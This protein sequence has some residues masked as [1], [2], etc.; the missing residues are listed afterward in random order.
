MHI[1]V[2]GI[3]FGAPKIFGALCG[4]P[5]CTPS[6]PA[7][8]IDRNGALSSWNDSFHFCDWSGVKCGKRHKRVTALF[9]ESPGLEVD[10]NK[11]TGGI[12]P[13]LA[14]ITTMVTF[15]AKE[16]PFGRSIPDTLGR[17][18]SLSQ[19][20]SGDCSLSDVVKIKR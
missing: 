1:I 6:K 8:V 9:L 17:W 12:P 18:R 14:N 16:N 2:N 15:S 19:F 10:T 4:R 7:L 11:L 5:P 13:F 20:G 3:N